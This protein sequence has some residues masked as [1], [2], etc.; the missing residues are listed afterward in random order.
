MPESMHTNLILIIVMWKI[1]YH[2]NCHFYIIVVFVILALIYADLNNKILHLMQRYWM[3][4]YNKVN[5]FYDFL[6]QL[7]IFCQI[8]LDN[9]GSDNNILSFYI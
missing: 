9:C 8:N 5:Y 2:L 6:S 4:T 1:A 3:R 7:F